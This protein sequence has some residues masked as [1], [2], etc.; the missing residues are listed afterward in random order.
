M[1]DREES[2]LVVLQNSVLDHR[3]RVAPAP[4]CCSAPEMP[5]WVS[6]DGSCLSMFHGVHPRGSNFAI[7]KSRI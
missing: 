5:A 6:G 4:L 2:A 1:A 3:L 7:G